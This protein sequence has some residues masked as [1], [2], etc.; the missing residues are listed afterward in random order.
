MRGA[1]ILVWLALAFAPGIASAQDL[2]ALHDVTGVAADD[3]LNIRAEPEASAAALGSFAP[4]MTG[5][6]VTGL[7]ADGRWGRVNLAEQTGW[8]SMRYLARQPG[9]DWWSLEKPLS[10]YGT[11]PFWSLRLTPDA[12]RVEF[13]RMGED[14]QDL[15][16]DWATGVAGRRGQAGMALRG[17]DSSGF[18]TFTGQ[19]CSDG[20]SDFSF[21]IAV[22][23]FL[24]DAA[25][26]GQGPSGWSG[27]CALAR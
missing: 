26:S 3:R 19:D 13:S 1:A 20:M 27:C 6:E 22:T 15:A 9:P 23:L 5:I 8:A 25:G 4:G 18:A 16:V 2:P 10:C 24:T 14:P 11:E 17:A 12:E 7:S 21:G